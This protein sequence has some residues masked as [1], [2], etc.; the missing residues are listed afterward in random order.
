MEA[1]MWVSSGIAV[2]GSWLRSAAV[3]VAA[4]ATLLLSATA[5]DAHIPVLLTSSDTVF[6]LRNSPLVTDGTT[7]FAFY[8]RTGFP[9]DTRAV[10]IGLTA[11]QQFHA[12]LL[13]PDLAPENGLP[14][15]LLPRMGVISPDGRFTLLAN[16]DRTSFFE[17][18]T[19]TAYLTLAE[20]TTVATPGIYDIVVVGVAPTR[21]VAVTG[22]VEQFTAAIQNATVASLADVQTWY[23]TPP[24]RTR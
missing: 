17:P 23:S 8:G 19:Q 3:A 2:R 16:T 11:G 12:E 21:F 1:A 10:R 5:A 20:T 15:R 13:I 7:S 4:T 18:F 6:G 22:Q 24:V 9:G 14:D